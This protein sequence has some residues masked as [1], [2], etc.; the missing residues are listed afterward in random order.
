MPALLYRGRPVLAVIQRAH[1]LAYYPYSGSVI[2]Q[3]AHRLRD[4]S[5]TAGTLRFSVERPVPPDV[6]DGLI[7]ARRDQIDAALSD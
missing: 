1:H 2:P 5:W 3:F 4:Y 7:V 6:V